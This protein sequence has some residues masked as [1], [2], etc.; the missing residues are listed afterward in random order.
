[1]GFRHGSLDVGILIACIHTQEDTQMKDMY[2]EL[3]EDIEEKIR[4]R[5]F[6][7]YYLNNNPRPISL[8]KDYCFKDTEALIY[9]DSFVY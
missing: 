7:R 5:N 9:K 6:S 3:I 4:V 1:M 2:N 8:E